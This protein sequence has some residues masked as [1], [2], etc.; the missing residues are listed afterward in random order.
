LLNRN[1]ISNDINP[2]SEVFTKPR[3]F[4]PTL[5]ETQ[6]RLRQIPF[7]K[8]AKA[9][10]DLSMF[11]HPSTEAEIVSLKRYF[12]KKQK[13]ETLDYAD[14][15]IKMV[16]T[17][18]LTGH[19]SGFFSVY[20]LPPNQAASPKSQIKINQKRNQKPGYKDT[21]KIIFKKTRSLLRNI[22]TYDTTNLKKRGSKAVFLAK[23]ARYV[24]EIPDCSVNLTVTSPPFLDVVNYSQD[25]WLRCWFNGI[26]AKEVQK[27]I[28]VAKK[29]EKWNEVMA[30]VFKELYRITALKGWVAFEVGEVRKGDVK[31][32]EQIVPIGQ[33]AGFSCIGIVVN[34]QNFTK[35]ANIWGVANN[36]GGTNSNRIVLFQ[37]P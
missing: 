14:L 4:V 7:K 19:S 8:N 30:S 10:I 28:T 24:E 35:T 26:S 22:T 25:N 5:K 1:V 2:L 16:A 32:D 23:D 13:Q 18:R 3:F 31:L 6:T 27:Q 37:K 36:Q 11:Y 17:N 33:R 20:T 15:W 21:K 34:Q 12:L 9:E 29:L